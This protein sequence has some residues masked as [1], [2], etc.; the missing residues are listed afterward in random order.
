MKLAQTDASC[1]TTDAQPKT[2]PE[3][4]RKEA[5]KAKE[6]CILRSTRNG[7]FNK[8]VESLLKYYF[9]LKQECEKTQF[10]YFIASTTSKG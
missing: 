5:E 7:C 4:G 10:C 8:M 9:A 6:Y 3:C 1:Y 2:M